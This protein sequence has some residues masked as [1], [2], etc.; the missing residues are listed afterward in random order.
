MEDVLSE[1]RKVV[2]V[3][4]LVEKLPGAQSLL[5]NSSCGMSSEGP[6]NHLPHS[7]TSNQWGCLI[8]G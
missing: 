6:H 3:K 7:L 2:L 4:S 5:P 1:S 8:L